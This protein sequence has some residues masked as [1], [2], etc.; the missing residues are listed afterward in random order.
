VRL[1][2][3]LLVGALA[4]AP[5]TAIDTPP[6]PRTW[7]FAIGGDQ[8]NGD[9]DAVAARLSPFDLVVIDGEGATPA[10][11]AAIQADGTLVLGYLSVGTIEK[12]RS[13]YPKLRRYRLEADKDWEDEW[14]ADVSKRGLRRA[15]RKRIAPKLLAKGFDGLFL[16]N[17]AMVS[18][19]K[20]RAQRAGM[21]K[22]VFSLA[23][24]V[25][26]DDEMLFAQNGF[27]IFNKLHLFDVLDGWNSE[28]VT[29]TFDDHHHYFRN[30]DQDIGFTT[31][32]LRRAVA[33]GIIVTATDYTGAGDDNAA[34]ESVANACAAGAL[35]YVSDWKLSAGRLPNPPLHCGEAS[36]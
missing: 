29:W 34:Q 26:A 23:G 35:P 15:F 33:K 12:F 14:F 1:A 16:D 9:A 11:I 31:D 24:L 10:D 7:A 27:G 20:Y 21:R 18:A 13:W 17:V 6:Q 3:A 5:A 19:R 30:S 32:E 22:L 8:L 4:A 36:G 2:L 28:S 25:H